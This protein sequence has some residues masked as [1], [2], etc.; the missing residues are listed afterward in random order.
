MRLVIVAVKAVAIAIMITTIITRVSDVQ[1]NCRSHEHSSSNSSPN[2]SKYRACLQRDKHSLSVGP[3]HHLH[4]PGFD[5]IHFPSDLSLQ[6]PGGRSINFLDRPWLAQGW[7]M[8]CCR[9][10][11]KQEKILKCYREQSP[12]GWF[13]LLEDQ[14]H[15]TCLQVHEVH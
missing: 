14:Q 10:H 7:P 9:S 2:F 11:N 6:W 15:V 8:T 13:K 4:L 5:D 12:V 3:A 1:G